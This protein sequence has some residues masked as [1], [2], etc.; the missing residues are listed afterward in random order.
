MAKELE[1]F[2]NAGATIYA[3]PLPLNTA[4]WAGDVVALTEDATRDG[5]FTGDVTLATAA[6]GYA[7]FLQAGGSPAN[8]DLERGD[9][10][11]RADKLQ[12]VAPD[13]KPTVDGTGKVTASNPGVL[14]SGQ[15]STLNS[16]RED[17]LR[18]NVQYRWQDSE[19]DLS[20]VTITDVS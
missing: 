20:D 13:N 17:M 6:D 8:T 10:D 2:D 19:G 9:V 7:I 16:I 4:S 12:L 18:K 15:E 14:S 5:Y 11:L 3:K 1:H